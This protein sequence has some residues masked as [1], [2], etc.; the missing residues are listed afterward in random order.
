MNTYEVNQKKK[1]EII[2][3]ILNNNEYHSLNKKTTKQTS[4]TKPHTTQKR[5][6]N[7]F[8]YFRPCVRTITKLFCNTEI[9]I[10]F[11]TSNTIKHHMDMSEKTNDIYSLSGIY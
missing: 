8:T 9:K 2:N 1:R 6:W 3:Q 10:A 7:T 11:R 5:K 4:T